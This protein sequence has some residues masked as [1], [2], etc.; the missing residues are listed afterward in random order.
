MTQL[1]DLQKA[2]DELRGWLHATEWRG[3]SSEVADELIERI[4]KVEKLFSAFKMA[5]VIVPRK[6]LSELVKSCPLVQTLTMMSV[7]ERS[8]FLSEHS[9]ALDE[10]YH[11]LKLLEASK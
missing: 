4:E 2:L 10:W 7:I 9:V 8:N 1:E 5:N 6:Q 11:K 3:V